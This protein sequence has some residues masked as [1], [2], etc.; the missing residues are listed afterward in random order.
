MHFTDLSDDVIDHILT[1]LPDFDTYSAAIRTSK[2]IYNTWQ[3]HPKSINR[4]V[5]WNV[6]GPALPSALRLV[7]FIR[8]VDQDAS[9]AHALQDEAPVTSDTDIDP[10]TEGL[11]LQHHAQIFQHLEDLFSR[12]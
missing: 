10:G 7:R 3:K 6:A 1:S 5:A 9:A 8:M 12:R 2:Q 11:M 4:E